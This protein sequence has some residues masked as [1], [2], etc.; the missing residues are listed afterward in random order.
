MSQGDGLFC[1]TCALT[2][3][4]VACAVCGSPLYGTHFKNPFF[5]GE[6]YCVEHKTSRTPCFSW[7]CGS[8]DPSTNSINTHYSLALD[9]SPFQAVARRLSYPC[10]MDDDNVLIAASPR[11]WI[12]LKPRR[13][14]KK[15]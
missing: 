14:T 2:V 7:Y 12:P 1:Q 5:E 3:F 13:C 8:Y 10:P 15:R 6:A 9:W 4:Y 11:W